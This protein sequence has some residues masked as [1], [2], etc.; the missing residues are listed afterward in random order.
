MSPKDKVNLLFEETVVCSASSKVFICNE[1]ILILCVSFCCKIIFKL[2][3]EIG[4]EGLLEKH[5][6]LSQFCAAFFFFFPVWKINS[7][8]VIHLYMF[9]E[10]ESGP[11]S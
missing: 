1:K 2:P 9:G 10:L 8:D 4:S 11:S 7:I 6:N 3:I 5:H